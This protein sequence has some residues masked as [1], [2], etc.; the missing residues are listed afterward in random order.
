MRLA[1]LPVCREYSDWIGRVQRKGENFGIVSPIGERV[2]PMVSSVLYINPISHHAHV[3]GKRGGP[4]HSFLGNW[5]CKAPY[6]P[7][8]SHGDITTRA[9][10]RTEIAGLIRRQ[11]YGDDFLYDFR[12]ISRKVAHATP[13]EVIGVYRTGASLRKALIP[14]A[15]ENDHF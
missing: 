11:T 4:C 14:D 15:A 13:H 8:H 12:V 5:R 7:D 9:A 2:Q 10:I 1:E 3:R 6:S